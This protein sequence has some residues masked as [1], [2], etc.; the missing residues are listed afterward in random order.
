MHEKDHISLSD[1]K[2][3]SMIGYALTHPQAATFKSRLVSFMQSALQPKF[4]A[5][6]ALTAVAI[7]IFVVALTPKQTNP[8]MM[9]DISDYMLYEFVDEV[10]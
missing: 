8:S 5:S 2:L 9:D 3:Q 1:E 7:I 10:V 6:T 4:M